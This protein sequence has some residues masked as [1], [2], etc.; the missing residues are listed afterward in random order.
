MIIR[1]SF[2]Q[3]MEALKQRLLNMGSFV[4][5]VISKAIRAFAELN[6]EQ[7]R[8]VVAF[9]QVIDE[10]EEDIETD[11][12]GLIATQQPMAKDLR[13]IT[14]ALKIVNDLERMADYAVNIARAVLR[15][16]KKPYYKPLEKPLED[17]IIYMAEITRNTVKM[18]LDAYLYESE[19]IA[20]MLAGEDEKIDDF[21]DKIFSELLSNNNK[22]PENIPQYTEVLYICSCLERI[23]D[24]AT[25]IGEEV[26]YLNSGERKS[27]N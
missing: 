10:M 22:S 16:S 27:L 21:Y 11:S 24:L 12:L 5:E 9:D 14:V 1:K 20:K 15:I 8:E 3:E 25:N 6:L 23:A 18:A 26:I 19:H 7:A 17:N 13:R 4:E 2:N